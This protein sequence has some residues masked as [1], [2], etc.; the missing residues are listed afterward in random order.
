MGSKQIEKQ[1]LNKYLNQAA[2]A[3]KNGHDED[4]VEFLEKGRRIDP[5]HPGILLVLGEVE[6]DLGHYE[7]AVEYFSTVIEANP[8]KS[9][10]FASRGITYGKMKK[11]RAGI[12]DLINAL[13]LSHRSTDINAGLPPFVDEG[14]DAEYLRKYYELISLYFRQGNV[15][16]EELEKDYGIKWFDLIRGDIKDVWDDDEEQAKTRL[17]IRSLPKEF[18]EFSLTQSERNQFD[19]RVHKWVE[20][21]TILVDYKRFLHSRLEKEGRSIP[22]VGQKI[23]IPS[24]ILGR[25]E[26][27]EKFVSS[28]NIAAELDRVN[29]RLYA[30]SYKMLEALGMHKNY[31]RPQETWK[32]TK[33][34]FARFCL[35]AYEADRE[36][37][38]KDK[39]YRR[40][41]TS[42]RNCVHKLYRDY[43][44]PWPEWS[45]EQC[46]TIARR[47]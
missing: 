40:K 32:G 9:D 41:Y 23:K 15:S 42:T 43:S 3:F 47:H 14:K 25:K 37:G 29:E 31:Q 8:Q 18:S 17:L 44:F 46:Y 28:L 1:T 5:N 34:E 36:N 16:V 6:D 20:M 19:E 30:I 22:K 24:D 35:D 11:Y 21:Y 45:A 12:E 26:L 4:A 27:V 10:A 33:G 39:N 13:K 2:N 7:K 38:K